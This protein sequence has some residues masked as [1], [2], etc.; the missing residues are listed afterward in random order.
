[1]N[2]PVQI[3]VVFGTAAVGVL[4]AAATFAFLPLVQPIV[5]RVS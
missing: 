4:A 5:T 1:M 2:L 3:G